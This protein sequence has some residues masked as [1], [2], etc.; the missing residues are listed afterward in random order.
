MLQIKCSCGRIA[1][2]R[3][4]KNGQKLAYVHC[5]NGCGG[6][7]NTARAAEI[8]AQTIENIGVKGEFFKPVSNDSTETVQDK[9]TSDF[10]PDQSDLPENL[11]SDIK[12]ENDDF[13]AES[14]KQGNGLKILAALFGTALFGG[15]IYQLSKLKG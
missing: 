14:P 12:I 3:H 6:L 4:R 13:E 2:V 1:E 10:K 11:E 8:E 7:T 15:G 5:V 9:Q